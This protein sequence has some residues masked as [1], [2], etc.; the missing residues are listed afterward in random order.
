MSDTALSLPPLL[1]AHPVPPGAD[2]SA[3]AAAGAAEGR[4]GAGDFLFAER[5]GLLSAA[6]VLEPE[7]GRDRCGEMLFVAMVAFGDALGA[8]A[9]PEVA[10]T[11][12]WPGTLR[13][14]GAVAGQFDLAL[15]RPCA[16][17]A[18]MFRTG[19]CSASLSAPLLPPPDGRNRPCEIRTAPI[20]GTRAAARSP[21]RI[22][23]NPSPATSSPASTAGSRTAFA[24]S[25]SHWW[26]RLDAPP[27]WRCRAFGTLTGLDEHGNALWRNAAAAMRTLHP[28]ALKFK[29]VHAMKFLRT[30][31]FDPSDEQRLRASPPHRT[32]GRSAAPSPLPTCPPR[33]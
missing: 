12:T 22:C 21:R 24:G 14:N 29:R 2:P 31:R 25:I 3:L 5:A 20:S 27:R 9:P 8:L 23:S 18:T 28:D 15:P 32:N 26:G 11:Y 4:L 30:L 17:P 16:R 1:D 6:L 33:R 19:W 10:V 7:I 13:L